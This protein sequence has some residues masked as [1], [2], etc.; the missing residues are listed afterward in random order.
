MV[1]AAGGGPTI[2]ETE[3]SCEEMISSSSTTDIEDPDARNWDKKLVYIASIHHGDEMQKSVERLP[4]FEQYPTF[5]GA[6]FPFDE[7]ISCRLFILSSSSFSSCWC[8]LIFASITRC[9]S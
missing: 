4:A 3:A 2:G 6:K 8:I 1:L 7:L 5:T 9:S